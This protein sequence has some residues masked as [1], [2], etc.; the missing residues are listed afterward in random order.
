MTTA[1]IILTALVS[2]SPIVSVVVAVIVARRN[3]DKDI[4][5]ESKELGAM[6]S[7]LG[8]IKSGIDDL[9]RSQIKN[10]ERIDDI[11]ERVTK[12]ETTLVAH[13]GDKNIHNT[14]SKRGGKK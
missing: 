6:Q 3:K 13:I 1:E 9:K 14:V 11:S 4:K 2:L 10:D 5:Q 8:Y 7:D 12:V